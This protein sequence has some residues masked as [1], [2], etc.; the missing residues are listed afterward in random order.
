LVLACQLLIGLPSA[1]AGPLIHYGRRFAMQPIRHSVRCMPH[2]APTSIH[3]STCQTSWHARCRP[4]P[5]P[6]CRSTIRVGI[7]GISWYIQVR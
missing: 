6:Q 3:P 2:N 4:H 7:A 5:P 1:R